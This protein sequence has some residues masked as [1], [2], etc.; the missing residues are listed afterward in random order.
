MNIVSLAQV[1]KVFQDL[2]LESEINGDSIILKVGSHEHPF[3]TVVSSD[4]DNLDFKCQLVKADQIEE[5]QEG[6]FA[7]AAL[8]ANTRI[9]PFAFGF[10]TAD[11]GV[12][13]GSDSFVLTNRLPLGNLSEDE[14]RSAV[15]SL[16]AALIASREVLEIGLTPPVVEAPAKSQ[17]GRVHVERPSCNRN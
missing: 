6:I 10:L 12:E 5:E 15:G 13:D 2:G 16:K 11:D 7:F 9:A 17:G 3:L 4:G 1:D 14:L 8:D